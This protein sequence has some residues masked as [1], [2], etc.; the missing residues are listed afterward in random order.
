MFGSSGLCADPRFRNG[1]YPGVDYSLAFFLSF[2]MTLPRWIEDPTCDSPAMLAAY[3]NYHIQ[4]EQS[5]DKVCSFT[6][7][8]MVVHRPDDAP[9]PAIIQ[10]GRSVPMSTRLCNV[11]GCRRCAEGHGGYMFRWYH[12]AWE[13]IY[14]KGRRAGAW[15]PGAGSVS[16]P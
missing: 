13:E 12:P 3:L 2:I 11:S 1:V 7:L 9:P 15:T 8:Y 5:E 6:D 4:N 16:H 10:S 14:M